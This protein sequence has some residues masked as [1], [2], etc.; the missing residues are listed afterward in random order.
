MNSIL[1][2]KLRQRHGVTLVEVLIA[3]ALG[4]VAAAVLFAT[5]LGGQGVYIKTRN[6]TGVHGDARVVL[7]LLANE[8]RSAGSDA[9]ELGIPGQGI[10]LARGDSLHLVSDLDGDR[11]IGLTE[12]PEDVL[13]V[14]DSTGGILTRDTGAGPVVL[15][16]RIANLNLRFL[17]SNGQPLA[18]EASGRVDPEPIR[19]VEIQVSV[20]N[21]DGTTQELEGVYSFRAR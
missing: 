15:L 17:D 19:A 13:Y 18:A 4:A 8:I 1:I 14:Y 7:G 20:R 10:A 9:G 2:Q 3:V 12:P 11:T 21:L 16:D 5:F 6:E